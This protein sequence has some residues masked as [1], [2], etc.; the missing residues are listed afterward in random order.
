MGMCRLRYST[1]TTRKMLEAQ[2]SREASL[3][4]SRKP[5]RIAVPAL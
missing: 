5:N 2:C 1:L 3:T 4:L